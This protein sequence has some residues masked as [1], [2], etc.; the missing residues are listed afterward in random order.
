MAVTIDGSDAYLTLEGRH[1]FVTSGGQMWVATADQANGYIHF[2]YSN[3]NGVSWAENT[4]GM[5]GA[6]QEPEGDWWAVFMTAD[7]HVFCIYNRGPDNHEYWIKQGTISGNSISWG[8]S[9]GVISWGVLEPRMVDLCAWKVSS[10]YYLGVIYGGTSATEISMKIIE[11]DG[12]VTWSAV[13]QHSPLIGQQGWSCSIDF[14]HTGDGKTIKD[15]DPHVFVCW[16]NEATRDLNFRKYTFVSGTTWTTGD[17]RTIH[18][19]AAN[20]I[21]RCRLKWDGTRVVMAVLESA[22][23]ALFVYDRNLADTTTTEHIPS[24]LVGDIDTNAYNGMGLITDIETGDIFVLVKRNTDGHVSYARYDRA[25]DSW[26][27]DVTAIEG[28]LPTHLEWLENEHGGSHGW[29]SALW[30][31]ND[32]VRFENAYQTQE[33]ALQAGWGLVLA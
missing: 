5:L 8:G 22:A 23:T 11:W 6:A 14:H 28:Q 19:G 30:N 24:E 17:Q 2:W 1:S 32:D 15:S 16:V 12:D 18:N 29:V 27:D 13:H 4:G 25:G 3:N 10:D 7:D 26:P 33:S 31:I 20:L 21:R 9:V